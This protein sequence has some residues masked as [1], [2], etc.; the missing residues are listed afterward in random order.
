MPQ[1][2]LYFCRSERLTNASHV[3]PQYILLLALTNNLAIVPE[4]AQIIRTALLSTAHYIIGRPL[5]VFS[6]QQQLNYSRRL[7]PKPDVS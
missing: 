5:K 6:Y 3:D 7:N 4:I 2:T 1:E